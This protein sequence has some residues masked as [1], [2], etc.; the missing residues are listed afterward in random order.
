R[1]C[2]TD[3]QEHCYGQRQQVI[4]EAFAFLSASPI[5]EESEGLM[6]H[7]NR[8]HHHYPNAER[9]DSSQKSQ[10]QA[11]PAEELGSDRQEGEQ[12]CH[13]QHSREETHSSGETEPSKPP[14]HLLCAV[15]EKDNSQRQS[16]DSRRR[17]VI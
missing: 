1:A 2:P 14:Q 10:N 8:D 9:R 13:V 11:Y 12:R 16:Q 5:H 17:A 15:R 4:L 3:H 7:L 6:Y